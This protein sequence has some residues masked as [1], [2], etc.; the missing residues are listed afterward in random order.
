[1]KWCHSKDHFGLKAQARSDLVI[2]M[3]KYHD[4]C[5]FISTSPLETGGSTLKILLVMIYVFLEFAYYEE[6]RNTERSRVAASASTGPGYL[7]RSIDALCSG[8]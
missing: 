7:L 4:S 3:A 1:M 5:Q 8:M 2:S 6:V